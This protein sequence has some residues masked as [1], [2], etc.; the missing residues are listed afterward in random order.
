MDSVVGVDWSS[1]STEL[2]ELG[3]EDRI[4]ARLMIGAF[5]AQPFVLGGDAQPT[6]ATS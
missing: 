3:D 6:A 5:P 4:S 1:S 2:D